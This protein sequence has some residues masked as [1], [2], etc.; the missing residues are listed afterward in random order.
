MRLDGPQS[1][2]GRLEEEEKSVDPAGIGTQVV[3]TIA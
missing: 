1:R 2:S 3:Q